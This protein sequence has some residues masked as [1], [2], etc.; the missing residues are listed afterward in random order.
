M[1]VL[2]FTQYLLTALSKDKAGFLSKG[3]ATS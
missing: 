3:L 1:Y 2:N